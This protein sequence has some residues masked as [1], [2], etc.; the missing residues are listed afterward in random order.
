VIAIFSGSSWS[1]IKR[2]SSRIA[3]A[4]TITSRRSPT[5]SLSLPLAD[6]QAEAVGRRL[7]SRLPFEADQHPGQHGRLSSLAAANS[8]CPI[9]S[10]SRLRIDHAG[11]GVGLAESAGITREVR[12]RR[13]R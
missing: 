10:R 4:G 13:A 1:P 12:R 11:E 5:G 3:R 6:R 8:T 9:I 2:A 7:A